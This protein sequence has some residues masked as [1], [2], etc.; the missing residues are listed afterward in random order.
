MSDLD[1]ATVKKL[2]VAE[3]RSELQNRGLD[4]KGNKPVLVE[5][6]LE[7]IS[8]VGQKNGNS[9][10]EDGASA[11]EESAMEPQGQE[12]ADEKKEETQMEENEENTVEDAESKVEEPLPVAENSYADQ[13]SDLE[14]VDVPMKE[15][16][17][18][19]SSGKPAESA[20]VLQ[21]EESAIETEKDVVQSA[22]PMETGQESASTSQTTE[23]TIKEF[24]VCI[25]NKFSQN[26]IRYTL[27][28]GNFEVFL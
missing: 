10:D 28:L 25:I 12:E 16:P 9:L 14:T 6:L 8:N 27:L 17:S 21:K 15:K 13:A 5:R 1:E 24:H 18:E 3:L 19:E 11:A 4:T 22:E 26:M 2:K 7:A 23:G 20:E